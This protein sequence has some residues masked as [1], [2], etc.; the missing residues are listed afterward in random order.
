MTTQLQLA[1]AGEITSQMREVARAEALEPERIRDGVARGTIVI[2]RNRRRTFYAVGVGE[3]MFTK[4][5]ANIGTSRSHANIDEERAK[6]DACVQAGAH[7]VMDLS[8]GGDLP[9]IR[10]AILDASPVMVG[11]VP[12]YAVASRLEGE[13]L[14]MTAQMLLDEIELQCD[15]GVDF[16]TVHC[17]ITQS[18]LERLRESR[19]LLGIVSRGG[20]LMARWMG[21]HEQENPL[22]T[23]FDHLISICAEYDV[24]LSLGD[25][26][27]PG[28]IADASDAAQ[29]EELATLGQLGRR[30]RE[31]GVQVMIEGPGHMP[32]DQ[33][34]GHVQ[35]QKRLC[36]SAPF[37]VLGPLPT[38]TGAGHDHVVAAIGGAVAAMHGA[39]FL[40]YVTSAEHLRLPTIEETREGVIATRLAAHAG[41]VVKLGERAME[42]DRAVSRA[43]AALDWEAMYADLLDPAL[44]RHK[45]TDSEDAE[46]DVCSMC[47][48][49][50][51]I[52]TYAR[53]EGVETSR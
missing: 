47:G 41:D 49:L 35:L 10:R 36:D 31:R 16:I 22:F 40:C 4:V 33:V 39:D 29:L 43:R 13:I 19:R 34:A 7:A 9:A 26:L 20:S 50:C 5:N 53:F 17:G 15:Q 1:R 32:L 37:Y 3:G 27:R 44:A 45:R 2:P 42:R 8:T 14:G 21:H 51:A 25:G 6:L 11:T 48:D 30:A 52:R 12:I 28:A 38:D 24:T 18:A 23:H 46:R